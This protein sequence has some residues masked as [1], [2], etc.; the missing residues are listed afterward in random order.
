M[1]QILYSKL[2]KHWLPSVFCLLAFQMVGY[3]Q[4]NPS[5]TVEQY[6]VPVLIGKTD[7][8][9]IRIKISVPGNEAQ[10]L[11][12]I[13]IN[14]NGTTDLNDI[15]HI[16]VFY[17]GNDSST[18]LLN[19]TSKLAIFGSPEKPKAKLTINGSQSLNKGDHYCWVS[20]ELNDQANMMSV[21][22]GDLIEL[23]IGSKRIKAERS[24]NNIK[25][26]I[27][28]AVRKHMQDSVHTYR[29]PG[30]TTTPKGTLLAVYDVRRESSR[31]LQGHMDIGVSRS[32][33]GGNTWEPMRIAMDMKEWGGLP[34]KFNGVSDACIL[35]DAKTGTVFLAG[36]WMHG[37][38]NKDGEW[39]EGLNENS[40][41]WNH[42]WRDK[43]S[44]PGFDVKQTSQFLIVKSTDDGKTWSDP[45]NITRMCKKEEW[46]LWAPAPGHGI[47]LSDGTLVFPTQ[48]RDHT[49]RPFS[50]I[51]CS[52][53]GGKTWQTSAAAD[54]GSTTENMA[55]QLS[56]GSIM[57]NMRANE[58]KDRKDNTNGRAV[59]VTDD[60]G[61]TW[62]AH[63][64]SRNALQEPVCMASLHKHRWPENGQEKSLLFFSNP[65][66]KTSRKHLTI[67]VSVDD[68]LTWP[69]EHWLLID[70]L[71]S[72]GYSCITSVDENTIGILYESSQADMV[73][74]KFSI[75]ELLQG[76]D[77]TAENKRYKR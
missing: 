73:F 25:Q 37:V 2:I 54:T 77:L 3:N 44:Q 4:H 20:Y 59:A 69:Q 60:L 31:D 43:G 64:T 22:D 47:T 29:I 8:P 66:T 17:A 63:S 52:K 71:N 21:V 56:D 11:S 39:V 26:R 10:T 50:N 7:N 49:G 15:K 67:K 72:R 51:T 74:Q 38:I 68:G 12:R 42:Q 28:Y 61:K 48:G 5:I 24:G 30:I 45:V 65:N 33:D 18:K 70:E 34:E 58:N 62:K 27:G 57:L 35:T 6:Q 75:K 40:N 9:I 41:E 13:S 36:L 19:N 46:W 1:K 16:R 23:M 14:T 53:D 76:R 55:V 32:T